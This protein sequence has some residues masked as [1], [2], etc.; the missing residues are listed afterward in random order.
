MQYYR[1]N[2]ITFKDLV[3]KHTNEAQLP[4][5]DLSMDDHVVDI[6]PVGYELIRDGDDYSTSK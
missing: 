2:Q 1:F 6:V 3:S 4:K 5:F